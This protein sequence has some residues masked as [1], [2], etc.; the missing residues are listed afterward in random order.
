MLTSRVEHAV[1]GHEGQTRVVSDQQL[2][3]A[4][5][6]FWVACDGAT[7][8]LS[9]E[10]GKYFGFDNVA[11]FIWGEVAQHI[12]QNQIASAMASNYG[13][14]IER[15]RTDLDSFIQK[16]QTSALVEFALTRATSPSIEEEPQTS[17][18]SH[19]G[20][21]SSFQTGKQ[22]R[23]VRGPHRFLLFLEAYAL[24]VRIDIGLRR[25]GFHG[26]WKR[27]G[28]SG[29]RFGSS[30]AE[31]EATVKSVCSPVRAAFRWY[32]PGAAC[33]QRAM[34]TFW[35]LR[36]RGIQ[37]ALCVGVRRHPFG[38]HVWVEF[39]EKVLDDSQRVRETYQTIARLA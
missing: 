26:L 29:K 18:N 9:M 16:L 23:D 34:T 19:A 1:Q 7:I 33:M 3:I 17:S 38:S 20:H 10:S 27:F 21:V 37:A 30:G 15:A 32:R 4:R 6:V 13:L 35:F 14:E 5:N 28:S 12:P 24:M 22:S 39:N 36:R 8:V 31:D 2:T 25:K 11:A